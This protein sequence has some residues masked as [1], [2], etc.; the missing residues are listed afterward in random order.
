MAGVRPAGAAD[1]DTSDALPFAARRDEDM[2][3]HWLLASLGKT[4][5][6]PGGR[7]L[8][9]RMLA[10]LPITGADVV[11]L[12]PGLGLTA[13]LLLGQ[14]P[15]S[16]VGVDEEPAAV[17]ITG[18]VVGSSGSVWEGSA[19]HT[20]LPDASADI[21]VNEA[22]LTMNTD[23]SKE[24]IV[25]EVARILR[26]GGRYAFH[27]LGLAPDT[28]HA[29]VATTIRRSLARSIKVNARPLTVAE[30][31]AL[32][33]DAGF[34][35]EAIHVADMGLLKFR[36]LLADEGLRGLV[37][38]GVNYL[39]RP[40]ARRR[41]NDMWR[42]FRRYRRFMISVAIVARVPDQGVRAAVE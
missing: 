2:P 23:R 16:Y 38:I 1:G 27:E 13:A 25:D 42:T 34:E 15:A 26:P 36:Q 28:I 11:E 41:I 21:V 10:H 31:T 37:T 39:R 3:G 17:T 19:A 35:V 4:V 9:D 8:T 5:L 18:G 7:A 12:A 22:M 24:R 14:R 40:A 32:V 6:R 29:D 33:T 30:W 20:G